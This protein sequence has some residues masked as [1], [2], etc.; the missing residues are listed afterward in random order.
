MQYRFSFALY[1]FLHGK[2]DNALARFRLGWAGC[3]RL[4]GCLSCLHWSQPPQQQAM[5]LLSPG[6]S[7]LFWFGSTERTSTVATAHPPSLPLGHHR[8]T[9]TVCCLTP[10]Y[11]HYEQQYIMYI[12]SVF[13]PVPSVYS[14]QMAFGARLHFFRFRVLRIDMLFA[15][16]AGKNANDGGWY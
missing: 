13:I 6:L 10:H 14:H 12:H 8:F 4:V 3:R 16:H 7:P 1:I 2:L 15:L 11:C 9:A 5:F